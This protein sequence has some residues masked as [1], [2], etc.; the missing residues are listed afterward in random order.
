MPLYDYRCG[1]C[2]ERLSELQ[3]HSE[4]PLSICPKCGKAALVR[5][6]SAPAFQL[7]GSGWY[8]TDFRGDK[9]TPT[10]DAKKA[11]TKGT[12]ESGSS[13]GVDT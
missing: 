8:A 2:G 11:E 13:S 10:P 1:A 9:K 12:G 4:P 6:V 5:E 7:K 3:K